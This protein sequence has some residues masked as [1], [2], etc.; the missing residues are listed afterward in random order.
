[1]AG[2]LLLDDDLPR[3]SAEDDR[4]GDAVQGLLRSRE[5][6]LRQDAFE[7]QAERREGPEADVGDL[8]L[9]ARGAVGGDHLE[10]VAAERGRVDLNEQAADAKRNGPV[11]S[12]E[13]HGPLAEDR[14]GPALDRPVD[15]GTKRACHCI[16]LG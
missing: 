5:S 11:A 10:D 13:D 14:E 2:Q 7:R 1:M 9:V 3:G 16:P 8:V 15:T 4:R 6:L 12:F